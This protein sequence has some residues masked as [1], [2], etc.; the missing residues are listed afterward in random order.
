MDRRAFLGLFS[1]ALA[2]A[3]YDPERLLW[4]P[5]TKTVFLP[6]SAGWSASG[7]AFR[8]DAF[9]LTMAPRWWTVKPALRSASSRRF[10][11]HADIEDLVRLQRP[12]NAMQSQL[13]DEAVALRFV[14][15]DMWR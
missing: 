14:G 11:L 6:P 2:T 4:R 3:A 15:G 13:V 9:A 8:R 10:D 7:L 5:G 12:F 1:T